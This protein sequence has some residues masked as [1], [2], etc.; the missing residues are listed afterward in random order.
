MVSQLLSKDVIWLKWNIILKLF[1]SAQQA[2]TE[3]QFSEL[4]TEEYFKSNMNIF[5]RI[6][7]LKIPIITFWLS[8]SKNILMFQK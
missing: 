2:H 4:I 7:S 3:G 5:C 1:F 6:N 8:I